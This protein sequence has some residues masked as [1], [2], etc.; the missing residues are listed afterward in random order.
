[1]MGYGSGEG[2]VTT[3]TNKTHNPALSVVL[4]GGGK[5]E[6]YAKPRTKGIGVSYGKIGLT[7]VAVTQDVKRTHPPLEQNI[8]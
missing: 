5:K 8:T 2:N 4:A 7:T 6:V 1:M 3:A